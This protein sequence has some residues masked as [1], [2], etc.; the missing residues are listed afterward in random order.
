MQGDDYMGSFIARQPNGLLCRFSYVTDY[1]TNYNMTEDEYI[2]MCAER[3]RLEAKDII[4][5]YLHNFS[6]VVENLEMW[7]NADDDFHSDK[8]EDVD[9]II[10]E[11]SKPKNKKSPE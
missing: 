3:A 6:E 11:M 7:K 8:S 2:E 10:K 1:I 5:N 4:Q 9:R